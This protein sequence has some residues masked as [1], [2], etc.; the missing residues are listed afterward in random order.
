MT[1]QSIIR[2]FPGWRVVREIGAGG[3]GKVYEIERDRFGKIEKAAVKVMNIP[4]DRSVISEMREDGYDDESIKSR[5]KSDM[6]TF[7]MEYDNMR[8]VVHTNIVNCDD[9]EYVANIDGFGYTV[10]LKMELLMPLM[11]SLKNGYDREKTTVALAKDICKALELCESRNIVHRDIK[12]QNLFVNEYGEYKLGDFGIAR[13]MDHA[14]NATKTGTYK[15]M[16]PEVYNNQPYDHNV[17]IYSL[18]LVMYWLLNEKRM[19]FVPLPP[20]VPTAQEEEA[21]KSKRLRGEKLSAPKYGSVG[22]KKIV[23]KACEADRRKRYQSAAEMLADLEALG[24]PAAAKRNNA[25]FAYSDSSGQSDV[26][27][28]WDDGDSTIGTGKAQGNT[29]IGGEYSFSYKSNRAQNDEKTRGNS[30]NDDGETVATS[31]NHSGVRDNQGTQYKQQNTPFGSVHANGSEKD[32]KTVGA[33]NNGYIHSQKQEPEQNAFSDVN[34]TLKY[35]QENISVPKYSLSSIIRWIIIV[36]LGVLSVFWSWAALLWALIILCFALKRV[37]L[38]RQTKITRNGDEIHISLSKTTAD[39]F[40]KS[41]FANTDSY[42]V[43]LNGIWIKAGDAGTSLWRDFTFPVSGHNNEV[44]LATIEKK[45][46]T[47]KAKFFLK[48]TL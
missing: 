14:T 26:S 24:K 47:H 13:E 35:L 11:A 34:P 48:K 33:K 2:V 38:R 46:G 9:I 42:A 44:I 1:D 17:D 39:N 27:G 7:A 41:W 6:D 43:A 32:D 22:L 31:Q 12:P 5:L 29:S 20:A 21:A 16:A 40:W 30:W 4:N 19:P 45:N 37:V 25:S 3:F 15:Y 23:L 10:Y 8:K 28:G 36:G 18:G